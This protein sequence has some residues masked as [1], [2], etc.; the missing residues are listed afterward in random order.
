MF[1]DKFLVWKVFPV[2]CL[3]WIL[4]FAVLESPPSTDLLIQDWKTNANGLLDV[5][6]R[7]VAVWAKEG[8]VQSA[9]IEQQACILYSF[10]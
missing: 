2:R 9:P 6:Q 1:L 7:L 8:F 3:R 4:Q 10:L 5:V